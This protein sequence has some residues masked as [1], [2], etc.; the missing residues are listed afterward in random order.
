MGGVP[1]N[2]LS[3]RLKNTRTKEVWTAEFD[4]TVVRLWDPQ[5]REVLMVPREHVAQYL[6]LQRDLFRGW[7]VTFAVLEGVKSHSFYLGRGDLVRLMTCMP[8]K[9][10]G[11]ARKEVRLQAVALGLSGILFLVLPDV[12]WWMWG[13]ALLGSGAVG[14]VYPHRGVYSLNAPLLF[15]A[16]V[17]QLFVGGAGASGP[18]INT[19]ALLSTVVGIMF[20]CW[21]VQQLA[22]LSPNAQIRVA[23]LRE[24]REA[25]TAGGSSRLVRAVAWCSIVVFGGLWAY[26]ILLAYLVWTGRAAQPATA[27]VG[28]ISL[29]SLDFVACPVLGTL[30][31][32]TGMVLLFRKKT[33][34]LEAKITGQMLVSVA[35]VAFWGAVTGIAAREELLGHLFAWGLATFMQPYAWLSLVAAVL[36]FNR[37]YGR[38]LDREL[39]T[40]FE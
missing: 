13:A 29:T 16:G 39:E 2:T 22:M 28:R 10:P 25:V 6:R 18:G 30:S 17:Y 19:M 37:W 15:F 11:E 40:N 9:S 26:S 24:N 38:A 32:L 5:K 20:V 7:I 4:T 34:Y 1:L 27:S 23:R 8:R 14:L 3:L 21:S 33:A 35:L 31:L 36:I 12:F